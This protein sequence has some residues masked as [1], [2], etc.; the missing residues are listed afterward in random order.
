MGWL[1]ASDLHP[2]A[3]AA[4]KADADAAAASGKP[5][6]MALNGGPEV[7]NGI[8]YD[9]DSGR[10]W[11]TGGR[12]GHGWRDGWLLLER[13][14]LSMFRTACR[15]QSRC[16]DHQPAGYPRCHLGAALAAA[17]LAQINLMLR[18]PSPR[19]AVAA[20]LPDRN[21]R[22][23][24]R[25]GG[26]C[27]GARAQAVHRAPVNGACSSSSAREHANLNCNQIFRL[28]TEWST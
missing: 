25:G 4:A 26:R 12:W 9:A 21:V 15:S 14:G 24:S 19:Q 3:V 27:A 10:L 6:P 17:A 5:A 2:R 1:R 18:M 16:L 20:H 11:I 7:L 13:A 23:G 28:V 22:S 8:A